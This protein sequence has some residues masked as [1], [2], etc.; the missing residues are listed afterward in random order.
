MQIKRGDALQV[1]THKDDSDDFT[2]GLAVHRKDHQARNKW[3]ES[4]ASEN[5]DE[6]IGIKLIV[7]VW[8]FS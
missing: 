2:I 7:S 4:E 6:P 3:S 8:Q 5:E 1:E